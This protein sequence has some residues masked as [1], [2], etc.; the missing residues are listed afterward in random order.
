M[1]MRYL[2]LGAKTCGW[3]NQENLNLDHATTCEQ[4]TA[5]SQKEQFIADIL[6][7]QPGDAQVS[8]TLLIDNG[9]ES[10]D[11][12]RAF[13]D[14]TKNSED[15]A[16]QVVS[17]FSASILQKKHCTCLSKLISPSIMDMAVSGS[18]LNRRSG[19]SR[20]IEYA[21]Q[22][23]CHDW[24]QVIKRITGFYPVM[25]L[26]SLLIESAVQKACDWKQGMLIVDCGIGYERHLYFRSGVVC[27][28][29]LV[30]SSEDNLTTQVS[31]TKV[32]SETQSYLLQNFP[33]PVDCEC[34]RVSSNVGPEEIGL[35]CYK[36]LL[37]SN[38]SIAVSPLKQA[39]IDCLTPPENVGVGAVLR[40]PRMRIDKIRLHNAETCSHHNRI[41]RDRRIGRIQLVTMTSL[42]GLLFWQLS[43]LA[44]THQQIS[45]INVDTDKLLEQSDRNIQAQSTNHPVTP[46]VMQWF[47]ESH[48]DIRLR[49]LIM[50]LAALS[51]LQNV[52]HP[53]PAITLTGIEWQTDKQGLL[54]PPLLS[55]D[56]PSDTTLIRLVLDGVMSSTGDSQTDDIDPVQGLRQFEI[57]IASLSNAYGVAQPDRI[58]YPFG[59]D[60]NNRIRQSASLSNVDQV[61]VSNRFSLEISIPKQ[62]LQED[63]LS[64]DYLLDEQGG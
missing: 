2:Y 23:D 27:F 42:V 59:A 37:N 14:P 64:L 9:T 20:R 57:F 15:D 63:M 61:S 4:L 53:L 33:L 19:M 32:Q 18:S 22:R 8:I 31:L 40:G 56:S 60:T 11:W 5:N 50:P 47:V 25:L 17:T 34:T 30:K 7:R 10:V 13:T 54:A 62:H 24:Y 29:R 12:Y 58:E 43:A 46:Q 45:Q 26:F 39:L 49:S 36:L 35:S 6:Q 51:K 1:I 38:D 28:S 21:Q 48:R 44:M 52:I 41:I 55:V 3:L 16:L